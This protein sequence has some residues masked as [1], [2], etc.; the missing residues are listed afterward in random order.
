MSNNQTSIGDAIKQMLKNYK[1]DRKVTERDIAHSWEKLM[2]P[3]INKHTLEITVRDKVLI[4][5]LDSSALRHELGFAKAK[6]VQ[7]INEYVG[8][9]YIEEVRLL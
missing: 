3:S 5:R 2:G 8:A 7:K 6:I 1:L 9:N 4:I